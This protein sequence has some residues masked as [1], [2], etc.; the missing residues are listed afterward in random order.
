VK[1][2]KVILATLVIFCAGLYAG[3]RITGIREAR[4]RAD[5][6]EH[7]ALKPGHNHPANTNG[8]PANTNRDAR[9]AL[10]FAN[11]PP[12][13]NM[14]KE[15]L[16]RLD[17]EVHLAAEQRKQIEKILEDS[18]KRNKEIWK[19][20]E[21]EM[22]EEMKKSRDL[23]RDVLTPDQNKRFDELMKRPPKPPKDGQPTNAVP[24]PPEQSTSLPIPEAPS[25]L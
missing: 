15:F 1:I 24:P 13:R 14:G 8:Y 10:P 3:V 25:K 11:R 23:L 19:K 12:F 7:G 16:E 5:V 22:R 9:L 2:W 6:G 18:Q 21:P 4:R 17:R 20:I